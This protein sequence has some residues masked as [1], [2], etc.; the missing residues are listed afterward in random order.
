MDGVCAAN[1]VI[2]ACA[3]RSSVLWL[4]R[5]ICGRLPKIFGFLRAC[6][7]FCVS[8]SNRLHVDILPVGGRIE[9]CRQ[10]SLVVQLVAQPVPILIHCSSPSIYIDRDVPYCHQVRDQSTVHSL[11]HDQFVSSLVLGTPQYS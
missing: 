1:W 6:C 9:V 7:S 8:K 4:L 3:L 11:L 10:C 5:G 2:C